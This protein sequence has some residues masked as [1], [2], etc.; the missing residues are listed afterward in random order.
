MA[1]ALAVAGLILVLHVVKPEVD[2]SWRMLSEYSVGPYGWLMKLAFFAWA[3][4]CGALFIA[5]GRQTAPRRARIGRW[6][7]PVVALAL[8]AAGLF[9]QDPTTV[10]TV[11]WHGQLHALASTV[12]IPG[13]PLCAMLLSADRRNGK[14]VAVLANLTWVSLALM[15]AYIAWAMGA[16]GGFGPGVYAGWLNRLVVAAYLAWQFALARR[17]G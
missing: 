12:G 13:V 11:S 6:L 3:G 7:L 16:K 2:P 8:V 1:S 9:D 14:L 10:R 4:G 15:A 17:L 5:L